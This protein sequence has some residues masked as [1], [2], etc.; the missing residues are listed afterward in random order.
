M[1]IHPERE[2]ANLA[3]ADVVDELEVAA[4]LETHGITDADAVSG[5]GEP[6][7]F[8]LATRLMRDRPAGPPAPV[9]EAA[10]WTPEPARHA[11]RGLLYVLPALGYVAVAGLVAGRAAILLLAGSLGVAWA[12]GQAL[13]YLGHVRLGRPDPDGARE[14]L[15]GGTAFAVPL[16]ILLI[17]GSALVFA[18]PP[19]AV[20]VASGQVV[21]LLAA[22]VPLVLGAERLLALALAPATV[23]VPAGLIAGGDAVRSAPVLGAVCLS[24]LAT[25]AVAVHVTRGAPVTVPGRA[26]LTAALPYAAYGLCAAGLV[27]FVPVSRA[28]SAPAAAMAAL[29]PLSLSMGLAEW[30]L[31]RL[32]IAGHRRLRSA[33]TLAG[34]ARHTRLAVTLTVAGYTVALAA[35]CRLAALTAERITGVTPGAA[36]FVALGAALFLSLML[37]AYGY[38]W[39]VIGACATAVGAELALLAGAADPETIQLGVTGLLAAGLFLAALTLLGR[40]HR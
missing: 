22:T 14:L 30:L 8:A 9:P 4:M 25:V 38:R 13:A 17:V 19:G 34:F 37:L 20:M 23:A 24:L 36:S 10:P 21:Y 26:E 15:R 33:T 27:L 16:L 31:V 18:V 7:V 2:I 3:G 28:G 12:A 6:D 11:L 5:Y 32:R 39:P 29:I 40:A 1:T 35:G